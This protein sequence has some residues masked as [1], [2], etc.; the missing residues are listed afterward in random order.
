MLLAFFSELPSLSIY[1]FER[2]Q[3]R[4]AGRGKEGKKGKEG[5]KE[6]MKESKAMTKEL[7]LMP[8]HVNPYLVVQPAHCLG[9]SLHVSPR[10]PKDHTVVPAFDLNV[11]LRT[12]NIPT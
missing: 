9:T 2:K 4:K 8:F 1:N 10:K 11:L 3:A 12:L 6:G 5:R 7:P